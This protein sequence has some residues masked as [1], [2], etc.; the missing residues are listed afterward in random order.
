MKERSSRRDLQNALLCTVLDRSLIS[1]FSLKIAER[2]ADFYEILQIFK[3]NF[4]RI[5]LNFC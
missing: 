2:V 4:A 5:L 3:V 1:V